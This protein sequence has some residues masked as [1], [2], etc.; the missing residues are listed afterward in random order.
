M[1]ELVGVVKAETKKPSKNLIMHQKGEK[2]IF[3]NAPMKLK[4]QPKNTRI[5]LAE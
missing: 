1:P 5:S 2:S 4:I 3:N